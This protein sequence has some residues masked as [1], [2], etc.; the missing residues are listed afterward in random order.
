MFPYEV[1]IFLLLG[2]NTF[3]CPEKYKCSLLFPSVTDIGSPP[4]TNNT[5][6]TCPA[7][8]GAKSLTSLPNSRIN[9]P[10]YTALHTLLDFSAKVQM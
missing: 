5:T 8:T 1:L 6:L 9:K 3:M 4:H 2:V 10:L 7:A